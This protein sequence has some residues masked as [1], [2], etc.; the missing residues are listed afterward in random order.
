M[1][2]APHHAPRVSL[3]AYRSPGVRVFSGR[4]RA[5]LIAQHI[6]QHYGPRV[7][8]E[9]PPDVFCITASFWEDFRRVLPDAVYPWV[10]Y[11]QAMTL[12]RGSDPFRALS[13]LAGRT[14]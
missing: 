2:A 13:P 1:G 4:D 14:P 8:I 5:R 6:R 9:V 7:E 10:E 11:A 3:D 12:G